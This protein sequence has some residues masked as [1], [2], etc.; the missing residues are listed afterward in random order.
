MRFFTV[1]GEGFEPP[2]IHRGFRGVGGEAAQKAAHGCEARSA[3]RARWGGTSRGEAGVGFGRAGPGRGHTGRRGGSGG[4]R[5]GASRRAGGAATGP[6]WRGRML[7][8][9]RSSCRRRLS[10]FQEGVTGVTGT[11]T[12]GIDAVTLF[13]NP[14]RH[15]HRQS[16]RGSCHPQSNSAGAPPQ[17]RRFAP[18]AV[19]HLARRA[20]PRTE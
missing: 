20:P 13:T 3:R 8:A 1:G 5:R 16:G 18:D 7:L 17:A 4:G 2:A 12:G 11:G 9:R 14:P 6:P 19:Q 10:L 15:R